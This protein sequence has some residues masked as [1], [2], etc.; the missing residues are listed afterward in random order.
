M[1]RIG[2]NTKFSSSQK[3][4]KSTQK[5]ASAV[6]NVEVQHF[7]LLAYILIQAHI[8]FTA[9]QRCMAKYTSSL[10]STQ[11]TALFKHLPGVVD[12]DSISNFK[13]TPQGIAS[14]LGH[15]SVSNQTQFISSIFVAL[16][17]GKVEF[18]ESNT[19]PTWF[20][21]LISSLSSDAESQTSQFTYQ[22][23]WYHS[24]ASVADSLFNLARAEIALSCTSQQSREGFKSSLSK[25]VLLDYSDCWRSIFGLQIETHTLHESQADILTVTTANK[26]KTG[27][28]MLIGTRDVRKSI[29]VPAVPDANRF[30]FA[31]KDFGLAKIIEE[32]N[33]DNG[34]A[35]ESVQALKKSTTPRGASSVGSWTSGAAASQP[36]QVKKEK[37]KTEAVPVEVDSDGFTTVR[38]RRG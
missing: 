23:P 8:S 2:S 16:S 9:I 17:N 13:P 36:A 27:T 15:C 31:S 20:A 18:L 4:G 25:S 32:L 38:A 29:H 6:D 37:K 33:R 1:A 34:L 5:P 35:V 14:S 30:R 12:L 28:K 10:S 22:N 19:P 21:T 26:G 3:G 24:T 11:L 7:T